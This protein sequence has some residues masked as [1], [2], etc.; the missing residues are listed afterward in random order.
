MFRTDRS[1]ICIICDTNIFAAARTT[2][3]FEIFQKQKNLISHKWKDLQVTT[4]TIT[5]QLQAPIQKDGYIA[6]NMLSYKIVF[7]LL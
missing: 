5:E 6:K 3:Q 1:Y 7:I 2:V 4:W